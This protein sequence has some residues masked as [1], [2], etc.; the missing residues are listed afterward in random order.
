M[1]VDFISHQPLLGPSG[2]N[3]LNLYVISL[4]S[5]HIYTP[6]F[7]EPLLLQYCFLFLLVFALWISLWT[8]LVFSCVFALCVWE[9]TESAPEPAPV[10]E[11]TESAPEPAP[12]RE[13]TESV[14]E[15]APVPPEIAASAAETPEVVTVFASVPL[16]TWA[17]LYKL[18][19]C[20]VA[21]WGTVCELSDCPAMAL[22]VTC[23]LSA[24]PVMATEAIVTSMC[25]LFQFCQIRSGGL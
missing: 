16:K 12:L 19:A 25:N 22:E 2:L 11:P 4:V 9:P 8:I 20:L 17:L 3:Y 6:L 7:C 18:S 1:F 10:R 13:P 5:Y 21:V 15:P 24:C 14:P 23:E